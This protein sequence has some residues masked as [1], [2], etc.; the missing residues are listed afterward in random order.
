MNSGHFQSKISGRSVKHCEMA[1]AHPIQNALPIQDAPAAAQ[2]PP[3]DPAVA[4]AEAPEAVAA[5][6]EAE[7]ALAA[8]EAEAAPAALVTHYVSLVKEGLAER[9]EKAV[10]VVNAAARAAITGMVAACEVESMRT[11]RSVRQ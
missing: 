6:A 3:V 10:E 7:A 9:V 8:A 11:L 2:Q 5:A 4:A 1:K